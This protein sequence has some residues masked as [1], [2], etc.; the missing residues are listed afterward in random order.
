LVAPH[1]G[2]TDRAATATTSLALLREWVTD[3]PVFRLGTA[4]AY[5]PSNTDVL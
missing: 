1:C 5:L 3:L 2:H 4:I